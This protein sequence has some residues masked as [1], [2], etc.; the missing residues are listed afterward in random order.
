[1]AKVPSGLYPEQG[2]AGGITF[3][4]TRSASWN[5]WIEFHDRSANSVSVSRSGPFDLEIPPALRLGETDLVH[6]ANSLRNQ[7]RKYAEEL[8]MAWLPECKG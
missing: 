7:G 2:R 4:L 3:L 6:R 8:A 5:R 1:M